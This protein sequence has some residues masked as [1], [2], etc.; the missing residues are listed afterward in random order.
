[1]SVF[2]ILL[3]VQEDH[4]SQLT[5][6]FPG[7]P[8]V[9]NLPTNTGDIREA[10]SI[11]GL[12]RSPGEGNGNPLQYSCLEN[13]MGREAKSPWCC[14]EQDTTQHAHMRAHTRTR[15]H[16]HTDTQKHTR[17]VDYLIRKRKMSPCVSLYSFCRSLTTYL[18]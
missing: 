11:P 2:Y 9:K 6:G 3:Y 1:M 17:I 13:S 7:G 18:C 4:M 16:T 14:K 5:G 10:G 12:G 15:T 8:V